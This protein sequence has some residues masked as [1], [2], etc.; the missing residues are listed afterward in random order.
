MNMFEQVCSDDLYMS[1]AGEGRGV[2]PGLMSGAG[3][4]NEAQCIISNGHMGTM[5]KQTRMKTLPSCNF[6]GGR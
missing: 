2:V 5:N 4:Y 1:L 3:L 6:V